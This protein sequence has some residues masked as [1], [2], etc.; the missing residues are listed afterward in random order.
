[1][2]L[3]SAAT[4]L[5]AG[6]LK[7]PT[8]TRYPRSRRKL[9]LIQSLSDPG[10]MFEFTA[11]GRVLSTTINYHR[12][13]PTYLLVVGRSERRSLLIALRRQRVQRALTGRDTPVYLL[14]LHRPSDGRRARRVGA[15]RDA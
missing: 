13:G 12:F 11:I 9:A 1:M 7:E 3:V 14:D 15:R 6:Q 5:P 4:G 10:R 8:P 2:L